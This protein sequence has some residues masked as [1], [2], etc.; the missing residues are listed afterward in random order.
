MQKEVYLVNKMLFKN[1]V[2]LSY[3]LFCSAQI[4]QWFKAD[5]LNLAFLPFLLRISVGGKAEAKIFKL[6]FRLTFGSFNLMM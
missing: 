1:P 5:D 3:V 2:K 4:L 6:E